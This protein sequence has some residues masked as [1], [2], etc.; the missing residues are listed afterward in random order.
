[1]C[2]IS[3]WVLVMMNWFTQAIAWDL[4]RYHN[5]ISY[6]KKLELNY[7][8]PYTVITLLKHSEACKVLDFSTAGILGLN[9]SQGMD[10][11]CPLLQR[12]YSNTKCL[13]GT[14]S[15]V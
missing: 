14:A 7:T 6:Q 4:Q 15:V 10:T 11:D 8:N 12:V 1:M 9:F 5:N 2:S 13:E 3:A